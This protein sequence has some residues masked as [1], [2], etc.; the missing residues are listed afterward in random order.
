MRFLPLLAAFL[1]ISLGVLP[2]AA[3]TGSIRGR[4]VEATT[5]QP[6]PGVNVLVEGTSR[7]AASD[8]RGEFVIED[9]L[10]GSYT[11][12]ASFLGFE[13]QRTTDVVVR[14][15]RPAFV[16]FQLR[17]S[18]VDLDDIVVTASP[19]TVVSDAPTSLQSLGPEEIR[20]TPGGQNEISRTLL[21]LP[22]VTGGID[23]RNDLLVR[24]GG[25]G[26]NAYFVDGIEVPQINHFATQGATGGALGLLNVNFIRET[27]FYTGGFPVR[28]GNAASS[29][30]IVENRP[31][32]PQRL[33]GDFTLGAS[34]AAIALDGSLSERTNW[35]F[36]VRRSYLQFLFQLLDLPIRPAYWDSQVRIEHNPG[37]RDRFTFVGIGAIDDFGIV[38][39]SEDNFE[40]REIFDRVLENDQRS[41]TA[42]ATWRRLFR[43]G[44]STL[45]VSRSFQDFRFAD[46][47][48]NDDEV[49]RNRSVEVDNRVRLDSDLRLSRALSL[50]LGGGV[51]L[52][53]IDTE[54]FER[55][56]P[57]TPF[58]EDLQFDAGLSFVSGFS[59]AQVTG[60]AIEGRL[61]TTVGLRVDGNSFLEQALYAS[62]RASASF[63]LTPR[64]AMNAAAGVFKQ[65]PAYI[66]LVVRDVQGT[67]VNREL[68][69]ISVNQLVG[70]L[71][72]Q[73]RPALR[74]SVEGFYKQY[75][76]Y[77]IS[78][79]DARISLANLGGDYGY[80]GAEPLLG[81]GRGRAYGLEAFAQQKFVE[82]LYFLGAY[83]LAWS[84]FSGA[85]GVLRPSSWD[86]RHSVSLTTGYRIGRAWEIGTKW[87]YLSG[88]PFT[89]FDLERS[90]A[91]YALTRRGVPDLDQLNTGRTPAYHRLDIRI[92]RRFAFPRWNAVA[93]IDIQ[94]AYNRSNIFGYSYTEDPTVPDRIRV[95]DNIGLLP[96]IGFTIEI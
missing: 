2:A 58:L 7:G 68:P 70:G 89:P 83:T 17:E 75:R 63:T 1:L 67:F 57:G 20:R 53:G 69:Y 78:A 46:V 50:G 47:D 77:P 15:S 59:Y 40:S 9:L 16:L 18:A 22:G 45:A 52:S 64:W 66:S 51:T 4:V 72:W 33:A 85:D 10:P 39:P 71:A 21:S 87:R 23:S 62:P 13:T 8:I 29:V 54:F 27:Q 36:S 25:P 88:R 74:L 43:G 34:E 44:V 6:L 94:N 55:A 31:G 92:D 81:T 80:I 49:L 91:E 48:T 61:T 84:E 76:D 82:R 11:L 56:R 5:Q 35:L 26:E 96:I 95:Q 3:Q 73:A 37:T 79:S 32:S 28:Y 86:V 14:P 12:R 24:G 90:A 41:Y 60:R 42:G 19:F 38:M 30:L 65:A 93:Y